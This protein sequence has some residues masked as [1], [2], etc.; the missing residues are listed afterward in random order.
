MGPPI[1][2]VSLSPDQKPIKEK[3]PHKK[4]ELKLETEEWGEVIEGETKREVVFLGSVV[5]RPG[6]PGWPCI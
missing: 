5:I 1:W 2:D 6:S 3:S 4:V